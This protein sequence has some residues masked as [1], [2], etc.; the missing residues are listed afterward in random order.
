MC[1]AE[2][3][4]GVMF[5]QPDWVETT[6]ERTSSID[7]AVV[8]LEEDAFAF[9]LLHGNFVGP[10]PIPGTCK[11]L[12]LKGRVPTDLCDFR[13][14]HNYPSLA[15]LNITA[16]SGAADALPVD[17]LWINEVRNWLGSQ[18][19]DNLTQGCSIL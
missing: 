8:V 12:L 13:G 3:I 10:V 4:L 1:H 16:A 19:P 11:F 9:I 2:R 15:V 18:L 14:E 6:N 5:G 17:V 7:P